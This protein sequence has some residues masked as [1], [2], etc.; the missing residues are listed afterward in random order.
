MVKN[1]ILL[2]WSHR[3]LHFIFHCLT[4]SVVLQLEKGAYPENL[5][6]HN[7]WHSFYLT[8]YVFGS[9]FYNTNSHSCFRIK[10]K[11]N[12]SSASSK[13]MCLKN[14]PNRERSLSKPKQGGEKKKNH[15]HTGTRPPNQQQTKKEEKHLN[16]WS[17]NKTKR[18]QLQDLKFHNNPCNLWFNV[19]L[20]PQ[21]P[22]GLLGTKSTGQPPWLSHIPEL[23]KQFSFLLMPTCVY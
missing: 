6:I 11:K 16:L 9:C 17:K 14:K 20:R 5:K 7:K 12:K 2:Y 3:F 4:L 23:W 13:M 8:F 15:S 19:A 10:I 1:E 18:G 21:K 22:S